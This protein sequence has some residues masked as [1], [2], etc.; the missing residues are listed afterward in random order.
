MFTCSTVK[1]EKS[2]V[3]MKKSGCSYN[4]GACHPVVDN[5]EGCN[6]IEAVSQGNYCG[7]FAEPDIKWDGGNCNMA[8]HVSSEKEEAVAKKVNPLKASKRGGR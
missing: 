2:C 7:I 1:P 6:N 8:T 3:F 4:G 5:C